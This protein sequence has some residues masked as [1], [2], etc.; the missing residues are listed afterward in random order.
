MGS[1]SDDSVDGTILPGVGDVFIFGFPVVVS[2]E[3]LV[4]NG[5]HVGVLWGF[6]RG[7]GEARFMSL[8]I[9]GEGAEEFLGLVKGFFDGEGFLGPVDRGVELFQPRE[10]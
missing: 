10:S 1:A 2:K 8:S 3:V 6:N 9:Y 5:V 7:S 4:Y